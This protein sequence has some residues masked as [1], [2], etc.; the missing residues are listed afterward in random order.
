MATRRVIQELTL[1]QEETIK[2][3]FNNNN[4]D[5][6]EIKR[7]TGKNIFFFHEISDFFCH[8]YCN[9]NSKLIL[10]KDINFI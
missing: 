7:K 10:I 4:W 3:L 5:Y 9:Q 6:K 8:R 2:A 1:E